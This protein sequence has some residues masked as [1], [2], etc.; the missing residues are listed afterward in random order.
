MGG[1]SL[2]E[3]DL[4]GPGLRALC[5]ALAAAG[6]R[7]GE[8]LRRVEDPSRAAIGEWSIGEVAAHVA[9]SPSFFLAVAR[10]EAEPE[11]LGEV[12]AINAAFLASD[13]ERRPAVLAERHA[14]GEQALLS[15]VDEVGGDP[16]IE[17]FR[18]IRVPLSTL[19]AVELGEVLVH[20]YDIA[21]AAGLAWPIDRGEAAAAAGGTLPMLSHV[22]DRGAAAGRRLR[23]ELRIRGGVR[24]VLAFDDGTLHVSAP[25]G[26]PVDCRL[27]V[28]P[29]TYLLLSFARIGPLRSTLQGKLWVWG[30]RPWLAARFPALFLR[31]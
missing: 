15:W 26:G 30:R 10:G 7:F 9:S 27:S 20:G 8:M 17:A 25:A 21:R 6:P 13:P 28:D 14:I 2:M 19:L 12:A 22:V 18:G 5:G 23:F 11:A 3:P 29:V 31:I 4:P 16:T 1:D 24:A